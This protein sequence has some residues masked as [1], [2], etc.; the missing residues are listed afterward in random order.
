MQA[1]PLLTCIAMCHAG[2]IEAFWADL[3]GWNTLIIQN[4]SVGGA[5]P[6]EL[7]HFG[8]LSSLQLDNNRFNGGIPSGESVALT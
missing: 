6:P 3:I 2:K 8:N 4:T 5:L 7:A 1:L